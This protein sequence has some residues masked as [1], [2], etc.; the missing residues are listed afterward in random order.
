MSN[1]DDVP[2]VKAGVDSSMLHNML[3]K[4]NGGS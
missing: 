4:I 3:N 2:K 1:T